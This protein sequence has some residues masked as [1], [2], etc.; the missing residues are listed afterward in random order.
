M[1]LVVRDIDIFGA[2]LGAVGEWVNG[3]RRSER[4]DEGVDFSA[5]L[6]NLEVHLVERWVGALWEASES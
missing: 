4:R 5:C 2:T 3:V 6:A 1:C